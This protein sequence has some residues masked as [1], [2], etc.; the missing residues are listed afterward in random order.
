MC[1]YP[2]NLL[3]G[4]SA[5]FAEADGDVN[6]LCYIIP[7][8]LFAENDLSHVH[9]TLAKSDPNI[10]KILS[11][12]QVVETMKVFCHSHSHSHFISFHL[13]IFHSFSN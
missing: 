2:K 7:G 13:I 5:I 1:F 3:P 6:Y 9:E 8:G 4:Y 10:S 12:A 11:N